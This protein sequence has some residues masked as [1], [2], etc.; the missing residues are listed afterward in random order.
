[1]DSHRIDALAYSLRSM[2]GMHVFVDPG[3][4]D[5]YTETVRYAA[6]P[7]ICWLSKWFIVEPYV[8]VTFVR[9][10][11]KK[12]AYMFHNRLIMHPVLRNDLAIHI[13]N[14]IV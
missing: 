2:A 7:L 5:T 9:T 11:P 14:T 3:M 13:G 10:K 12:M 1:M 4:V 8:E 6:H